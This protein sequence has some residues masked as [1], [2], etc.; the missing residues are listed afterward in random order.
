MSSRSRDLRLSWWARVARVGQAS[1]L[2]GN[3]YEARVDVPR[4]LA[5]AHPHRPAG[6]LAAGSPVRYYVPV[7]PAALGAT[8]V[9]LVDAWGRG[10]DRRAVVIAAGATVSAVVIT[11]YL[12]RTVNL[13]L[14]RSG[15]P[16]TGG[17]RRRLASTWHRAN[18][19]RLASLAL[20]LVAL[21]EATVRGD[22]DGHCSHMVNCR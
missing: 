22:I 1:W 14:L 19:V 9:V 10:G 11:G 15:E 20:A 13:R 3:L 18:V 16:V 21:R 5:D 7:V 12:V 4:L 17:E 6:V 2:L 8:G